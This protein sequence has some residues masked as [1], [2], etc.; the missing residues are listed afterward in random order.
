[1]S[2]SDYDIMDTP[3]YRELFKNVKMHYP[4][5]YEYIIHFAYLSH[6]KE[7]SN[8]ISDV[9]IDSTK[10]SVMAVLGCNGLRCVIT[11]FSLSQ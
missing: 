4:D 9:I 11:L 5:E 10:S 6:F 2:S 1:M 3:E 7:T 8:I